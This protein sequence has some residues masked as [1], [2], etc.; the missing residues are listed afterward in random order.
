MELL[1]SRDYDLPYGIYEKIKLDNDNPL[2]NYI[3][4]E[5]L[6]EKR[7]FTSTSYFLKKNTASPGC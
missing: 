7:K 1:R 2:F 5:K 6:K 4:P 3:K